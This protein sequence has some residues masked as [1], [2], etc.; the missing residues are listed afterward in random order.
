MKIDFHR[1]YNQSEFSEFLRN[2][3]LPE[4]FR[5]KSEP[6]DL[7]VK[8]R[9]INSVTE[10][11]VSEQIDTHVFEV[12]HDSEN[13]PRVSLS[14][15]MF[16]I[17][18]WQNIH[19]ALAIFKS[20]T[21]ENYRFSLVTI[22]FELTPN[23]VEKTYSNPRRYS[24]FLG[25]DSKTHTPTQ[26]LIKEGRIDTFD[27]LKE[28]FSV[29]I[30]NKEFYEEIAILFTKLVGGERKIRSQK[31]EISDDERW[32][33]LPGSQDHQTF[34]EFAVRLI[35]RLVFCWFLKK[36]KSENGIPLIPDGILS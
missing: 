18:R 23:G 12:E 2:D 13:D 28:R 26:F 3:L 6:I 14:K 21:S 16:R 19:Q 1:P 8:T 36:K 24:Y 27:E 7:Q 9:Y 25:P 35:G 5:Q 15:E 11:G 33:Q 29:E 30:V 22:E 4:D 20:T 34:E 31:L 10:I 17:M 32:L